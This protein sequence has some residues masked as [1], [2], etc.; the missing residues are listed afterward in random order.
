MAAGGVRRD[1]TRVLRGLRSAEAIQRYLDEEVKYNDGPTTF[2][3]PRRVA[4]D[5]VAHC[6]EGALF[7]A[8]A[9]EQLDHAPLILD[10]A[11]VRDDD[12]V[13]AVF[14]EN[15]HWGAIGKS[16]YAGLRY[17]TPVYRTLRELVMSYFEHYYNPRGEK[18]LRA[19]SRPILLTRFDHLDWRNTEQDLWDVAS[20]LVDLPHF[21][22][23][24]APIERKRFR[25]DRRLYEAGRFGAVG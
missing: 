4:R 21:S 16:N 17:R 8:A 7:A 12:H 11:A 25:M 3:S 24:P 22:V 13:I 19:Y 1:L 23:L 6:L 2:R 9:L 10:L 18:T 15:G 5:R 20:Y 14:R